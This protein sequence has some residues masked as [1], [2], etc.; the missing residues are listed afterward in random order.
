LNPKFNALLQPNP[1]Q[2]DNVGKVWLVH[3]GA[4]TNDDYNKS[5]IAHTNW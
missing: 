1:I 2:N 4:S 3:S 5:S